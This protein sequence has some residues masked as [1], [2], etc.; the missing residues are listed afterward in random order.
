MGLVIFIGYMYSSD[1]M[2]W[3]RF[4][5]IFILVCFLLVVLVYILLSLISTLTLIT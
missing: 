3:E 5:Y 2:F 4:L 1:T